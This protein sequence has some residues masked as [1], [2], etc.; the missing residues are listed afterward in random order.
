MIIIEPAAIPS[1]V[2]N[3]LVTFPSLKGIQK[4]RALRL[5][6]SLVLTEPQIQSPCNKIKGVILIKPKVIYYVINSKKNP[7]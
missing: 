5:K 2:P 6:E 4:A 1:A 3:A 7:P